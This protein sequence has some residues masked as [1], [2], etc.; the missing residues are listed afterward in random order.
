[1]AT[2]L[3][4]RSLGSTGHSASVVGLG[5]WQLGADWGDVSESAARE[6][7]ETSLAEG[8]TF[9]DTADVYGDG[10]SERI[11]GAFLAD[12][13]DEGVFVATEDGVERH[14]PAIRVKA[15]D[16]TAAGDVFV[17]GFVASLAAGGSVADAVAFGQAAAAISVTRHGAQPSIPRREEIIRQDA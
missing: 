7:L 15:V 16:T 10:R 4:Q 2:G 17:G 14:F 11:V 13:P 5:T 3:D 8:V 12:H 1:M 9:Y 6:V